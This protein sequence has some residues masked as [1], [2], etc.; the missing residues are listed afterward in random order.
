MNLNVNNY[1]KIILLVLIMI[2]IKINFM[3]NI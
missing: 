2:I 1:Y 3:K